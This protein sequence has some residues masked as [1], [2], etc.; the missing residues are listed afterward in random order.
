MLETQLRRVNHKFFHLQ[1]DTAAVV[2]PVVAVV[3]TE[4]ASS[5]SHPVVV[6]DTVAEPSRVPEVVT[7]PSNQ[8]PVVTEAAAVVMDLRHRNLRARVPNAD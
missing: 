1:A 3:A 5:P 2:V 8:V 6:A 4:V 7:E